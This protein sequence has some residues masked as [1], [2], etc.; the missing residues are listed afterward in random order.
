MDFRVGRLQKIRT[1]PRPEDGLRSLVE[2]APQAEAW[3]ERTTLRFQPALTWFYNFRRRIA[4]AVVGVVTLW[5]FVHVM[6]GPNGMFVYTQKKSDYQNLKKEID[7]LQK[8]NDVHTQQIKA[9]QTD[10]KMIEREAREQLH[11]ARPG[12]VVMVPPAPPPQPQ[13]P[14][15]SAARK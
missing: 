1:L 2:R 15:S 12:E 13:S 8:D 3:A 9:L 7:D 10:P 11:Y 6:L 5:M 14:G 4:T